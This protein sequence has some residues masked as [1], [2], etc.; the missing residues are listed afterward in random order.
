M[1]KLF[2]ALAIT[3]FAANASAVNVT[4]PASATSATPAAAA[5]S[6]EKLNSLVPQAGDE[7]PAAPAAKMHE[8]KDQMKNWETLSKAEKIKLL[9]DRH[10]KREAKWK[11]MSED[12]KLAQF[13]KRRSKFLEMRQK[14]LNNTAP[15]AGT[16]TTTP[17]VSPAPA[18]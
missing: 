5:T 4:P 13:E 7:K 11:S 2:L 12:Q 3:S 15:A 17:A 9:E 8:S 14:R 10:A 1:K 18:K 6:A 16:N